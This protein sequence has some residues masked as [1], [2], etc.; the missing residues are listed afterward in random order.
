LGDPEA[1]EHAAADCEHAA[2]RLYAPI[3]RLLTLRGGAVNGWTGRAGDSLVCAVDTRRQ[4]LVQ[5][6]SQLHD[7]ASQL[8]SAAT[9]LREAQRHVPVRPSVTA[10]RP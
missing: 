2:H 5:A 9:R 3:N 4:S 10:P 7:A 6:Q 1:C 8:R